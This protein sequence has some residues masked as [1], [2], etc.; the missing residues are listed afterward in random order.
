MGSGTVQ[1][2]GRRLPASGCEGYSI[3]IDVYYCQLDRFIKYDRCIK[4]DHENRQ[5]LTTRQAAVLTDLVKL[6]SISCEHDERSP[7]PFDQHV[8]QS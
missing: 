3:R 4:H 1:L 7:D 2:S 5:W 8:P 6:Q